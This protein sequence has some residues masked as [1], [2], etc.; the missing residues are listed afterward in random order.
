MKKIIIA[1]LACLPLAAMAQ[2]NVWEIPDEQTQEQPKKE[3]RTTL[4][5]KKAKKVENP[6][7]LAGAVPVVDGHVVFTLDKDVPGM[8]ADEIYS[9]VY[10]VFQEIAEEGKSADLQPS[11][12]ISAVNKTEHTI[13]AR[14]NE[15]LVFSNSFLSLDRTI[16]NYN[17]IAQAT[18]GHIKVTMERINYAYETSRDNGGMKISADE[19]I[20]DKEAIN[21]KGDKL[22]KGNGK[23][24]RKTIDR[25]DNI[26]SRVLMALGVYQPGKAQQA[27]Q[28]K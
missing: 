4:I 3:K 25:K 22:Y 19:W 17:L 18:D 10:G 1:I 2:S 26:F 16:M 7:Y 11:S 20:T 6:K 15:W 21:K 5:K 13:A 12:R 23:F 28:T 9:K 24:R 14:I 8:S 27:A